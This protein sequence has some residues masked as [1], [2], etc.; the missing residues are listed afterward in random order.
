MMVAVVLL[1][2]GVGRAADPSLPET[3]GDQVVFYY[4][5]RPDFTTF[6]NLR[7]TGAEEITASVLFYGPSF[8]TPFSRAVTLAAGALTILD[9]GILR[10]NGLPAQTGAAFATIVNATGQPIAQGGLTGNSTVAN[11]LTGSA[12]GAA[13]LARTARNGD[14]ERPDK[15][16]VIGDEFRFAPLKADGYLLAAY[17]DPAS[18]APVSSSGNQLIFLAF[19]DEYVPTY[20]A[21]IGSTTWRAITTRGNGAPVSDTEFTANGVTVTDIASVAGPGVNG[22]SGSMVLLRGGSPPSRQSDVVYF[23]ESLGT[24]G[25]GYLLPPISE[26]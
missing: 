22:S 17:Y 5:A 2:A 7:N 3:T 16:A 24:F 1:P 20:R 23:T 6:I 14:F 10:G 21:T 4:D 18:L 13:G 11:L 26:E 25:T 19:E 8:S 15:G 9:V 12:F